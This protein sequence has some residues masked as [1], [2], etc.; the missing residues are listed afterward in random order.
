MSSKKPSKPIRQ[1]YI[2]KVRY[3][4]NLPPPPV[5]P[6]LLKYNLTELVSTKTESEQLMLSLFRKENFKS[7]IGEIDDE[8]GMNLNLI[9]N[10]GFLDK[11]DHDV[12]FERKT[13]S[14]LHPSDRMLLRDAGISK[15]SKSE[16]GVA[17]LRRT[18]YISEKNV[19]KSSGLDVNKKKLNTNETDPDSQLKVIENMF[20]QA[21]ETLNDLTKLKHP[22]K[23]LLKAVS[24]WPLLPDTSMMD[25]KFLALKFTGSAS[26]SRDLQLLKRQRG[27]KFDEEYEKTSLRSAIFKPITSEDGEWISMYQYRDYNDKTR[28]EKLKDRLNSTEP[29][30]PINLLDEDEEFVDEY[31]FKFAKNYDMNYHKFPEENTELSVKFIPS[32]ENPKKRTM[33]YYY[34]VNGRIE[35]KKHRDSTNT[36]INKF[37]K[38]NTVDVVNFKL[39]EP[40]TNE[41]KKM[42]IFRSEYDP[43]EYE[44]EEDVEENNEHEGEEEEE[45]AEEEEEEEQ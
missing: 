28:A 18:E 7:L 23:K 42:D 31:K 12:I 29:E 15:I 41:L 9:N 8:F 36:E 16:P 26:L 14:S 19:S 44:G 4:N 34:P 3:R 39:R 17:F 43:M 24:T 32:K 2:A 37:L 1:D 11:G 27:S 21:Q 30:K 10:T 6:K 5:N 38:N 25:S 35:L 13:P 40:T 33:A 22:K 45:E 20:E